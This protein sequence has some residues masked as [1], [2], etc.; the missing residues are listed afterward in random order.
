MPYREKTGN[1][2][3][4]QGYKQRKIQS[5]T[6]ELGPKIGTKLL[7]FLVV[8]ATRRVAPTWYKE[9]PFGSSGYA[10]L[11]SWKTTGKTRPF[12]VKKDLIF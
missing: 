9:A 2:P 12:T 6:D 10:G 11:G 7:G 8:G 5:I 4:E 1:R 3:E